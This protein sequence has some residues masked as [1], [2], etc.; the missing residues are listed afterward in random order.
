MLN[1]LS[2][3]LHHYTIILLSRGDNMIKE[4]ITKK[5]VE[6]VEKKLKI[7]I[8]DLDSLSEVFKVSKLIDTIIKRKKNNKILH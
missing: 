6:I 3:I 7:I 4:T 8:N 1:I 2:S 5:E